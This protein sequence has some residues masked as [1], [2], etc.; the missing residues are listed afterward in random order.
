VVILSLAVGSL[1]GKTVRATQLLR[2]EILG[3]VQRHQSSFPQP[4]KG[5]Q[6]IVLAQMLQDLV[7]AGLQ[8]FWGDRIEHQANVVVSRNFLHA[9]QGLAIRAALAFLQPPLVRQKR[10]TLHEKQ[11]KR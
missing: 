4:L 2:T 9:E 6:T 8:G 5:L 10:L 3:P 11:G 7:E 1:A